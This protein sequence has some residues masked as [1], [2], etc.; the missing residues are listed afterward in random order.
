MRQ[1][2]GGGNLGKE[3]AG[4][5][6]VWVNLEGIGVTPVPSQKDPCLVPTLGEKVNRDPGGRDFFPPAPWEPGKSFDSR[7]RSLH[8][9][10]GE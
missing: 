1:D 5:L 10:G 8:E 9:I 4:S 2:C 3:G 6:R 7:G